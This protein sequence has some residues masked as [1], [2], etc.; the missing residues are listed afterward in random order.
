MARIFIYDG[1]EYPD[2][3]PEM[4]V[5]E[6][7]Q[8]WTEFFPELAN[9]ETKESKRGEDTVY[10]FAKRVGTKGADKKETPSNC[11]LLKCKYNTLSPPENSQECISCEGNKKPNWQPKI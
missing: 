5:D 8:S 2:P 9:A 1:K 11:K 10:T 3:A 6:V 7:R 4:P